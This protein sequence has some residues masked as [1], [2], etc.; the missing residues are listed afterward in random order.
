MKYWPAPAKLNLFLHVVGRRD[1][2]YHLLQTVFQFLD[3]Q[4][5]LTF[6]PTTDGRVTLATPLP[7]VPPEHDLTVRAAT[8]LKARAGANAGVEI[9]V[10]KRL[11]VGGGLGGGSSDGATT[12]LALN[13]LWGLDLTLDE[14]AELGL[15]LGA[16]VPVFVRG[17]AAWAEG[18]GEQLT[19]VEPA[20][21]WYLVLVPPVHVPTAAVFKA[22][23]EARER[24]LTRYSP[25]IRIRD[26]HAGAGRN[27]LEPL[28]RKLYPPVDAALTWLGGFGNARMTGSGACVFLPVESAEAG[29][30]LLAQAPYAGFVAR[31]VN[32]HPVHAQ[33]RK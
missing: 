27:D 4:D 21:P 16:D 17:H 29:A 14:L 3:L 8:L 28:V 19:P 26:F 30:H 31:G 22:Y 15:R 10:R 12:L 2:G 20:C 13:T 11:P 18:V 24:Q 9:A 6:T 23:A 5:E 1:D 33:A 32:V 7:N 25:A